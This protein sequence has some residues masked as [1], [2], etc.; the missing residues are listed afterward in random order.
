MDNNINKRFWGMLSLAMKAGALAVGES[1]AES[2]I[3]GGDA[4]LIIL[5]ADASEN[6]TKKFSDMGKFREVPLIKVADR[7]TI[8]SAIGRK[9][10][11]I[12]AVTE[13]GFAENILQIYKGSLTQ[14]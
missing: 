14:I 10:A 13:I 2:A 5:S 11:V 6:T 8:G 4:K 3:R 12:I 7:D 1:R 9:F